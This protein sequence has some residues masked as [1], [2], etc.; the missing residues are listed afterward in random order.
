MSRTWMAAGLSLLLLV[1]VAVTDRDQSGMTPPS[2]KSASGQIGS[3]YT[4]ATY[5]H[6]E[7][8]FDVIARRRARDSRSL[9][10]LLVS[11]GGVPRSAAENAHIQKVGTFKG[12][13][14]LVI[15][16][17][18]VCIARRGAVACDTL[19]PVLRRGLALSTFRAPKKP[20][21]ELTDFVLVGIAP[22]GVRA[23]T[24]LVGTKQQHRTVHNNVYA[25]ASDA[26]ITVIGLEPHTTRAFTLKPL[27]T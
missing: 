9:V 19:R 8:K 10:R 18:R 20:H 16:R 2:A 24:L 27:G 7:R 25:A 12:T 17:N 3:R 15:A 4:G 5:L 22:D 21:E 14:W 1:S 13:V 23:V 26:P 6:V 11:T